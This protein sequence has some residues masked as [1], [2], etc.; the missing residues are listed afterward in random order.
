MK[1][2]F[3]L[4]PLL[5]FLPSCEFQKRQEKLN[6]KEED[7]KQWE[8]QLSLTEDSLQLQAAELAKRE[9][10]LDSTKLIAIDTLSA[11]YPQVPG[12]WNVLMKCTET[13]CS[14][15][16]VGD[17]KIEQWEISFSNNTIVAKAMSDNKLLRIYSGSF[18]GNAFELSSQQENV[19][20]QQGAK[21]FV[22]LQTSKENQMTGQREIS[23]PEG[24]RIV[25][26]LELS[27]Q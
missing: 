22:R 8:Q 10:F 7:L 25:Y 21:M 12:I 2:I 19:T 15:S 23:R 20:T 3:F 6:K 18:T 11:I 4:I 17:T 5:I 13:T 24:C 26:A 27:K 14:G 9:M 16:A 1:F